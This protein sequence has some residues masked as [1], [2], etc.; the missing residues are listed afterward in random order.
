MQ[1]DLMERVL[2]LEQRIMNLEKKLEEKQTRKIPPI[3]LIGEALAS[4]L[5]GI[6]VIG[7]LI[8]GV[9]ALVVLLMSYMNL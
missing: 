6:F 4:L 9:C 8:T 1:I 2:E 3:Q 7:P 5:F